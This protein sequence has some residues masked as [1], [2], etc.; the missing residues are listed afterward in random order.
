[1]LPSLPKDFRT[2]IILDTWAYGL[3]GTIRILRHKGGVL[4][5]A[6][7]LL[8]LI[9]F[10]IFD[11]FCWPDASCVL[12]VSEE[13]RIRCQQERPGRKVLVIPNGIDCAAVKQIGRASCRERV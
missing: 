1:M 7:N 3:A 4:I 5:R 9:R 11:A 2:P 12:V 6:R 13:D 10:S 8:K